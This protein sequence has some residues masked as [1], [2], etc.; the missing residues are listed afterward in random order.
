MLMV[1]AAFGFPET[2]MGDIKTGNLAT[3]KSL[4]RPTEL[5][6]LWWQELWRDFMQR[7]CRYVLA[8]SNAAPRGKLREARRRAGK[9]GD[10][11]DITIS[12]RYPAILEHDIPQMVSAIVQAATLGGFDLG[13]TM[14]MKTVAQ[15]LLGELGVE[16]TEKVFDAMYPQYD[17]KDYA[18]STDVPAPGEP[19]AH[20]H[21]VQPGF[22]AESER[23]VEA[24]AQLKRASEKLAARNGGD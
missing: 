7:I 22:G 21:L 18:K 6:F 16:D 12:M 10:L 1:C 4:D 15:M 9:N 5:M 17:P 20:P 19:E 3:A 14:D 2:F 8:S 11:S 24:I 23:M 13:G